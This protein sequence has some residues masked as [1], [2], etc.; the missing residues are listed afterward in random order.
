MVLLDFTFC[1]TFIAQAIANVSPKAPI[2]Q[3]MGS[4]IRVLSKYEV[5]FIRLL[6]ISC[7]LQALKNP[8]LALKLSS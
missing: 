8:G 7:F 5:P 6:L 4:L 3:Y 1:V 2:A